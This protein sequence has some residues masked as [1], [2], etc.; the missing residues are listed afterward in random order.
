MQELRQEAEIRKKQNSLVGTTRAKSLNY[1]KNIPAFDTSHI[2]QRAAKIKSDIK[3]SILPDI[4]GT[5][6]PQWNPTVLLDRTKEYHQ[7]VSTNQIHFEIRKGL[8]DE[9]NPPMR[10][11]KIYDGVDT[12]NSFAGWDTSVQFS[13][14]EHK[15]N[16]IQ[17]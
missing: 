8:R 9:A 5:K 1:S 13:L 11:N 2:P 4:L 14:L 3:L 6:K 7:Q 15:K 16:H 12:R 10:D 17:V